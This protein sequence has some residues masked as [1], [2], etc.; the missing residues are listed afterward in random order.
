MRYLIMFLV[1]FPVWLIWSGMFDA[2]HLALGVVSCAV[3]TVLSHDL[4][5]KRTDFS[6]LPREAV[7][8]LL[9]LPWLLYQVVLA[10]VHVVYLT[11][12][13]RMPIDPQIVKYK[14]M[15]KK[16]LPR[17]IFANSITLTPGTITADIK[18]GDYIVH[19][20]SAKTADDLLAGDM[21]RRVA[22]IFEED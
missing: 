22:R 8:F 11:L 19:A 21:E 17:V 16:D 20:L 3:V 1:L 4:L 14:S 18:D 12:H 10:N 9:Y 15:L 7:R 6:G 13:P 2:F 5:L